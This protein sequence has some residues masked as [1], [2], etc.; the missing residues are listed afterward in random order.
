MPLDVVRLRDSETSVLLPA[1]EFRAA[2]LLW[3]AA[4]HQVPAASLPTDDRL[5]AMLAGY[6][7][8]RKGWSQAKEGA[9][10]GF[11]EC[12][13]GRL[14]HPVIAEKAL[15]A[16]SKRKKQR[17]QTAAATAA[18]AA[19]ATEKH[20]ENNKV[21]VRDGAVTAS[22]TDAVAVPP[23]D[24]KGREGRGTERSGTGGGLVARGVLARTEA[25]L[26][27]GPLFKN[28]SEAYPGPIGR[29]AERKFKALLL[30]GEN[31]DPIIAAAHRA[32]REMPAEQWLDER[33]WMQLSL[34]PDGGNVVISPDA[35]A[36]GDEIALIAGQDL[37]FIEPGWCGA[38]W[39]CQQWLNQGWPR[40]LI[41]AGVKAMVARKAPENISGHAYFEKGLARFIA[42]QTRPVAQVVERPAETV[43]VTRAASTRPGN[44]KSGVAAIGRV[45]EQFR[46]S[47]GEPGGSG[48][49]PNAAVQRLQA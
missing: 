21:D 27:A 36:L 4:W 41:V 5:L 46:T 29:G 9:L 37:Q 19:R 38:A 20:N 10:R 2:L 42:D 48:E 15:E 31:A 32:N 44:P 39:R 3:C 11:I 8:Y 17:Q 33:A 16:F 34:L 7:R 25:A 40:E 14:Y 13:D 6:G 1:T 18:A 47:E 49:V 35:L 28:F 12:S 43:E 26:I 45:Y 22:V 23:T 30:A 24:T